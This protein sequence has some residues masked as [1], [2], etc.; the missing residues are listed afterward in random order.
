MPKKKR[1]KTQSRKP[2]PIKAQPIHGTAADFELNNEGTISLLRPLTSR[3][4]DW[5]DEKLGDDKQWFGDAVVIEHRYVDDIV[6][7][8][9]ADGL[10]FDTDVSLNA[11]QKLYVIPDGGGYS[12]LGFDVCKNWTIGYAAWCGFTLPDPLPY[13]SLEAYELYRRVSEA[14]GQYAKRT[15]T[16]CPIHLTPQLNGLEDKK[17]EVVDAHGETRT[18]YVGKSTGWAPMHLEIEKRNDDGGGGVTGAPFKSVRVI[19]SR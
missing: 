4:R 17:V 6:T 5:L 9:R 19:G 11:E 14:A 12:C 7:G 16:R 13:A 8:I 1:Y 10:T 2:S 3:G 18:F 15:N